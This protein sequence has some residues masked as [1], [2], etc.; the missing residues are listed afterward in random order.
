MAETTGGF[1]SAG[2]QLEANT[3]V[4]PSLSQSEALEVGEI[5]YQLGRERALAITIEVQLREWPV[6]HVALP[7]AKPENG[8]WIARKARVVHATGNSTMYERVFA[9]ENSFDW[10]A[11]NNLAEETHAIHGGCVLGYL[12]LTLFRRGVNGI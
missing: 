7:G 3:L 2:L 5:A 8:N 12:G 1:T 6:F 10:Y 11:K 4:L 9:E